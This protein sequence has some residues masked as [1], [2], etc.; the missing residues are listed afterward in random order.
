MTKTLYL[1]QK[2]N[3]EKIYAL[4]DAGQLRESL[5][6]FENTTLEYDSIQLIRELNKLEQNRIW[7]EM[8]LSLYEAQ[9]NR[10]K[11][12]ILALAEN[13]E[14]H[15]QE[16]YLWNKA[17]IKGKLKFF[18][19][20]LKAYP[21]GKN[22]EDALWEVAIRENSWDS[23]DKYL[24]EFPDGKYVHEALGQMK[25]IADN[26]NDYPI[27]LKV[28]NWRQ[29]ISSDVAIVAII[30]LGL[31]LLLGALPFNLFSLK[32]PDTRFTEQRITR[33][34]TE[35]LVPLPGGAYSYWEAGARDSSLIMVSPFHIGAL[36]VTQAQWESIL[37]KNPSAVPC[38]D[39]PVTQVSWYDAIAFC[40]NLSL[41]EGLE[42]VY[43]LDSNHIDTDNKH[44][45]DT[46]KWRVRMNM[47]AEGYRLP[48]EA[49]WDLAARSAPSLPQVDLS[50]PAPVADSMPE[51]L[52]LLGLQGNVSE[53]VWDWYLPNRLNASFPQE[54]L[55]DPVGPASGR[56]RVIKGGNYENAQVASLSNSRDGA[57]AFV[58]TSTIGLRLVRST[59]PRMDLVYV[60]GGTF[61]MGSDRNPNEGPKHEVNLSSFELGIYEITQQQWLAVMGDSINPQGFCG[62]CA[63]EEVSWLEAVQFCNR[64]S[65]IQGL[66]SVYQIDS[67]Q[68]ESSNRFFWSV[69][70]DVG[71]DGYRLPTEAEWEYAARGGREQ[72]ETLYAGSNSL[73][74]VGWYRDNAFIEPDTL[75]AYQPGLKP[76]GQKYGNTLQIY[77]M[78][79]NVWEWCQDSFEPYRDKLRTDTLQSVFE[80]ESRFVL[81]GGSY[82]ST[83]PFTHLTTRMGRYPGTQSRAYG[84]RVARNAP[85]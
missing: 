53:W 17:R 57:A 19:D 23:Y 1:S 82:L 39:C 69:Y 15:T 64:L 68:D 46:L 54:F 56:T 36:E 84:F 63:V 47:A 2:K 61:V 58:K 59:M 65:E 12:K 3:L 66:T 9:K 32:T 45:Y 35:L 29:V 50:N 51:Q 37:G 80:E 4:V 44:V 22:A 5:D 76:V 24:I 27:P 55:K 79:G 33:N 11:G 81:R 38:P 52:T 43:T 60:Q 34:P 78:T 83:E 62:D 28:K 70:L 67:V 73:Q 75:S 21:R 72:R 6:G 31:G 49:E 16:A 10:L 18:V 40:N 7:E 74:E 42:P 8:E 25:V 26:P 20:Y 14:K 48:T 71:A 30:L 13:L 77:D 85:Q 41:L